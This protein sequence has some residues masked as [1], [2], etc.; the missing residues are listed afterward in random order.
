MAIKKFGKDGYGQIELNHVAFRRDGRIEAQC[1]LDPQEFTKENGR[2]AENGTLFAIDK[3]NGVL[4]TPTLENAALLPIGVNYSS[5]II[6]SNHNRSLKNFCL[7]PGEF[8]PRLGLLAV[9]DTFT[10]NAFAYD[11]EAMATE[12]VVIEALNAID[13]TPLYAGI[14]DGAEGY[15]TLNAAKPTAG[16][17][18]KVVQKTTM[19][20]GQLAIKVQVLSA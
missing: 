12:E 15:L 6:Y 19:P 14:A 4:K 1:E 8:L 18:L 16:P 10:T 7:K 17:V 11:S 5:E 3:V 2:V 20:D 13:K 9:G